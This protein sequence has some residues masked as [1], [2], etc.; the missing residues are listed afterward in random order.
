MPTI[1][2][3]QEGRRGSLRQVNEPWASPR[4]TVY[5]PPG[6]DSSGSYPAIYTADG[7]AWLDL[8]RLPS[9]LEPQ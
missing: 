1:A 7:S 3:V 8:I 5:L 6:Y 2:S 9:I 4:V